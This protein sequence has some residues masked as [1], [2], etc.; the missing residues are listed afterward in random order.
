MALDSMLRRGNR[1]Q[2]GIQQLHDQAFVWAERSR[3]GI[4]LGLRDFSNSIRRPPKPPES[5]AS[6]QDDDSRYKPKGQIGA[7]SFLQ[8]F[9]SLAVME[10]MKNKPL[11]VVVVMTVIAVCSVCLVMLL[12]QKQH[13]S[14]EI[15]RVFRELGHARTII[16]LDEI[17]VQDC[18]ADFQ[19]AYSTYVL[20]V[21]AAG[22]FASSKRLAF[23]KLQDAARLH[24]VTFTPKMRS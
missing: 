2:A 3:V 17:D 18:P 19:H 24:G 4:W 15:C 23:A 13:E 21:R 8:D 14:A 1:A 22:I 12:M 11:I 20:E 9:R 5:G 7:K 16:Y 6:P 10:S